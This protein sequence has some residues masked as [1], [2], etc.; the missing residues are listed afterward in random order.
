MLA[1]VSRMG[2]LLQADALFICI[3]MSS[4]RVSAALF[5]VKKEDADDESVKDN[6]LEAP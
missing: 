6:N 4:I 3:S 1:H 2:I 5:D